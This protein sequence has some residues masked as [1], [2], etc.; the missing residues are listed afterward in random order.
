MTYIPIIETM[1]GKMTKQELSLNEALSILGI[2]HE[3]SEVAGKRDW[4]TRSGEYLG[5]HGTEDGME[6]LKR[7][8][9]LSGRQ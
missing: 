6:Y 8:M 9:A 3:P 7:I 5:A 4:Y 1:E 2:Q